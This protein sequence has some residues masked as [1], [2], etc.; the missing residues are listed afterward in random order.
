M[1]VDQMVPCERV[2]EYFASQMNLPVSAGSVCNFKKEGYER[3]E[4]FEK[5]VKG[6]A[7]VGA[8][9]SLR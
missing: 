6:R 1:S 7:C 8:G 5:W 9:A 2:S 4:G 3:L